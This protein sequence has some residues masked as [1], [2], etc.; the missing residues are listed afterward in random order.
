MERSSTAGPMALDVSPPEMSCSYSLTSSIATIATTPCISSLSE[1]S[2]TTSSTR[3]PT[4]IAPEICSDDE[5]NLRASSD[6]DDGSDYV[7]DPAFMQALYN[8]R[9]VRIRST[10]QTSPSATNGMPAFNE[11]RTPLQTP[12][13][14]SESNDTMLSGM[15]MPT[16]S[17]PSPVLLPKWQ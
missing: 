2:S 17:P 11:L 1:T 5:V 4:S 15:L 3:M 10:S 12:L 14:R 8:L 13:P 9:Q 7:L 16:L 6:E